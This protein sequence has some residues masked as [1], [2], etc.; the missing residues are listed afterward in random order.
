MTTR[1]NDELRAIITDHLP[2]RQLR[3]R[4]STLRRLA[5]V[6]RELRRVKALYRDV[7][8]SVAMRYSYEPGEFRVHMM[9][10]IAQ[11]DAA[12]AMGLVGTLADG[13]RPMGAS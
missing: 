1:T 3:V 11:Y 4:Q 6:E 10:A 8:V 12:K 2:P 13:V 9:A 5:T 7:P